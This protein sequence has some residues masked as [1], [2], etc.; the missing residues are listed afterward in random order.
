VAAS[1]VILFGPA[2]QAGPWRWASF[3]IAVGVAGTAVRHPYGDPSSRRLFLA[4]ILIA[5]LDVASFAFSGVRL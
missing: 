3:A 5:A 1:A 4:I 2:G